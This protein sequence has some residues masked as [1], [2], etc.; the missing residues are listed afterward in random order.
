MSSKAI[1][2]E[3]LDKRLS[4]VE[5]G[6]KDIWDVVQII[7][8]VLI[9]IA[10]LIVGN[11]YSKAA[12]ETEIAAD[13]RAAAQELAADERTAAKE[14]DIATANS[15]VGQ[16]TV[17]AS[18]LDALLSADEKRAKLATEIVLVA[19]PDNGPAL[20]KVVERQGQSQ[21]TREYATDALSRRRESL[22]MELFSESGS[23]RQ[24]AYAGLMSGWSNDSSLVLEV[25]R[26]ARENVSNAN[27]I[28]NSLVLLSHMN[29]QAL[30]PH[31]ALI[32]A[33]ATEVESAGPKIK[34]RAQTLRSRLTT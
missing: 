29:R 23:R 1:T 21:A 16:A 31:V 8:A 6:P 27:G 33:F 32:I 10:I 25:I 19:M 2:L 28:Y 5:K 12:K 11:Q 24:E 17:V 9:P 20:V 30:Q 34:Q 4:K 7:G 22:I 3:D 15:R 26:Y 14:N 18:L 13:E